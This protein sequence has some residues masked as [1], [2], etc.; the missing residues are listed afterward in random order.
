MGRWSPHPAESH[1]ALPAVVGRRWF[2]GVR[3][4]T[5]GADPSGRTVA[6]SRATVQPDYVG[7]GYGSLPE[8]VCSLANR[9]VF[10][11]CQNQSLTKW[12]RTASAM[13]AR[14]CGGYASA[15]AGLRWRWCARLVVVRVMGGTVPARL[16]AASGHCAHSRCSCW[17]CSLP[18]KLAMKVRV[19]VSCCFGGRLCQSCSMVAWVVS[20]L[21]VGCCSRLMRRGSGW[22]VCAAQNGRQTN[23]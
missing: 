19:R 18:I 9:W 14:V 1:P 21:A 3:R 11:S 8:G 4:P 7:V 22:L 17:L 10:T 15:S 13:A 6:W 5:E 20:W 23:L 2:P 16:S 12:C